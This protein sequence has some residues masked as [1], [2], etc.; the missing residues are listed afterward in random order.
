MRF[1]TLLAILITAGLTIGVGALALPTIQ[2]FNTN[3]QLKKGLYDRAGVTG[4]VGMVYKSTGT[5]TVWS[6]TSSLF[7]DIEQ[8]VGSS[9]TDFF[10]FYSGATAVTGTSLVRFANSALTI[11]TNTNFT[12]LTSTNGWFTSLFAT[13][14]SVN[15][16]SQ[17]YRLMVQGTNSEDPFGIVSSTGGSMLTVSQSG[18][19][20]INN[21]SAASCDVKTA[22]GALYC[23]LDATGST[24][25]SGTTGAIQFTGAGSTFNANDLFFWDNTNLRL[26]INSTTPISTLSVVG[27]VG[28]NLVMLA[29]STGN[30]LLTILQ[31]GNVGIGT[32]TQAFSL[33]LQGVTSTNPFAIVS[34]TGGSMFTVLQNGNIGIASSS[35]T[36]TLSITGDIFATGILYDST[37]S[38]GTT[39]MVLKTTATGYNWVATSSLGL[40][41]TPVASSTTST[42]KILA[43]GTVVVRPDVTSTIWS[44]GV[45]NATSTLKTWKK[46]MKLTKLTELTCG[47]SAGT[48]ITFNLWYSAGFFQTASTSVGT[49]NC[50]NTTTGQYFVLTN[51][52]P[53]LNYIVL[54]ATS[55]SPTVISNLTVDVGGFLPN[56]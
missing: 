20:T 44:L 10:T 36:R 30:P 39:G 28:D 42:L 31:N 56:N 52:V 19:T 33:T 14:T 2:Y 25:A 35:P 9:T 32:S 21:L 29:S 23:G 41:G 16:T 5:S 40:L 53:A 4:T 43:D 18:T 48:G 37:N 50:T 27:K 45:G 55:A 26:G 11:T 8:R 51:S 34:S 38:A 15:T 47:I 24:S 6:T 13:S 49:F 22:A 1:K 17:T 3:V 7:G 12:S 54:E 46:L